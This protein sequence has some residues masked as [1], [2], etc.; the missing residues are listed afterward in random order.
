VAVGRKV[1]VT[2]LT[3]G[4][5]APYLRALEKAGLEPLAV[6]PAGG[7]GFGQCGGLLLTGG[8]DVNPALYGETPH[9]R[10]EGIDDARDRFEIALLE[11]AMELDLPVLAI[12]RGMQLLNVY[13]GGKLIQHI[14]GHSMPRRLEAHSVEIVP[15]TKLGALAG[16]KELAVNSRHH[17]AAGAIG[18]GLLVSAKSSKDGIVE[19]LELPDRRF[20][21]GV[22][23]HPEDRIE[24]H[25]V[26]R[27]LF[28]AF[29]AAVNYRP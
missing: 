17:Q 6:S 20:V 7:D 10:T 24:T 5:L 2:F 14:P 3:R 11:R 19:G 4:K 8:G 27:C 15:R 1:W 23:W 21:V 9:G 12:C 29:A 22:Q 25:A 26:D 13:R 16:T 28:E 18:A